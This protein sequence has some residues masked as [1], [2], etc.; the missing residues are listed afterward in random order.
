MFRTRLFLTAAM[1]ALSLLL[2]GVGANAALVKTDLIGGLGE[3]EFSAETAWQIAD[4]GWPFGVKSATSDDSVAAGWSRMTGRG[5]VPEQNSI[6][7][8]VPRQGINGS[9]CQY[10]GM[11]GTGGTI[12]LRK[13]L[14]V[15]NSLRSNVHRGDRLVFH[16]DR[17]FMSGYDVPKGAT[18]QCN[19]AVIC[20]GT[21]SR[22]TRVSTAIPVS[23]N[24]SSAEVSTTVV[25]NAY[26]ITLE[27]VLTVSGNPGAAKPGVYVDGARL[28]RKSTNTAYE[29][30]QVPAPRNRAIQ[31]QMVFFQY[32]VTDSY[33]V[34]RDYDAV[35][36]EQE[37][38]YPWVLRLKYYNP[39]IKVS[40]YELGGG[41]ADWRDQNLVD[42]PYSNCPFA[43]SDVLAHHRDWLY[44]RPDGFTPPNDQRA[45][46]LKD[47]QYLFA[48]TDPNQYFVHMDAPDYQREWSAA[49][50]DK[51]TRYR[52]D[53]VWID[54]V[55]ELLGEPGV[56]ASRSLAEPQSFVHGVSP[57][58]HQAG[59]QAIV[60][61]SVCALNTSPANALFDPTWKTN[62]SYP[63]SNGYANNTPQTTPDALSQEWG[64]FV[65]WPL[66][67]VNMNHYDL[68][69]WDATLGNLETVATWNK[70]LPVN[71]QKTVL[72]LTH[73][74]DRP[75]DPASG[76]NGWAHFA[77]CSYMLAQNQ[78]TWFGADRVGVYDRVQM[79]FSGT[80]RL[81]TA[82][83]GRSSLASDA[84]L[85]MRPY[86]NGLVL[87]NGHPT[88][89]RTYRFARTVIDENNLVI[90]SGRT[91]TLG[92]HTGRMY[93][94]R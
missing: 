77:L 89:I 8:I 2:W 30:E 11:Q 69:Y 54:A 68:S 78:F 47:C 26:A 61:D 50:V 35:M 28:Y 44:P 53:A 65:H 27:V 17:I 31:T 63:A 84:S 82:S 86:T 93:F 73:G 7:R 81:G 46:W 56:P 24:A 1:V 14:S 91:V 40:L 90:A 62:A 52:L 85:Q 9:R 72:I 37:C 5:V 70:S 76:P 59:L 67:G 87:V 80:V 20:H 3:F 12:W 48:P 60:N 74:V 32:G 29:M 4:G 36:L 75:E 66:Y 6:Y 55:P 16:I 79:D 58:L 21:D 88:T 49:V 92:P 10:F 33:E 64:F 13:C 39:N 43:F 83:A 38:E 34:A 42:S 41:V 18:V 45:P 19:M 23:S 51:A 25:A 94:Y 71:N 57:Y 22:E 15:A